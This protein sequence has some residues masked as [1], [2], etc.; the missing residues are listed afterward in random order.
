MFLLTIEEWLDEVAPN[1]HHYSQYIIFLVPVV[2]HFLSF[3]VTVGS[4]I[5]ALYFFRRK[6]SDLN[7]RPAPPV[8]IIKPLCGTDQNLEENL[9]SHIHQD[10]PNYEVLFSV[11]TKEDAAYPVAM[12]IVEEAKELS[13]VNARVVTNFIKAGI[14]PKVNN[15]IAPYEESSNE[16]VYLTDS[17]VI[18]PPQLLRDVMYP[19]RHNSG[20][21]SSVVCGRY[22]KS[23]GAMLECIYLNSYCARAFCLLQ[24]VGAWNPVVG[25]AMMF[26]RS[27]LNEFGGMRSLAMASAE[28]V[29]VQEMFI[30]KNM[31]IHLTN[32]PVDEYE[33]VRSIHDFFARH[34]RWCVTRRCSSLPQYLGEGLSLNVSQCLFAGFV[35]PMVLPFMTFWTAFL[36]FF[37][38]EWISM[39]VL[40]MHINPDNE[41]LQ[42]VFWPLVWA[43]EFPIWFRGLIKGKVEWRGRKLEMASTFNSGY[44]LAKEVYVN[45]NDERKKQD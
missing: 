43:L 10:Y 8:T 3:I 13:N 32:E 44:Y 45:D 24:C 40:M 11:E 14:N 20:A 35:M 1:F 38:I 28:D 4:P 22:P 9:R 18:A 15:M 34:C 12:K 42:I 5:G 26:R 2:L 19:V 7:K 29:K 31:G 41:Y 30:N 17:N 27:V 37:I 25:K 39:S 33:G 6:V 23:F 21:V 16:W 36:A